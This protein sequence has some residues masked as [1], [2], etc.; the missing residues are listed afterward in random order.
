MSP[1]SKVAFFLTGHGFGHGVRNSAVINAL[2]PSVEVSLFTS[3]PES[4]FREEL[5]RPYRLVPCEIDCGCVQHDAIDVDVEATLER[6]RAL[7]ARRG[8]SVE[9]FAKAL[10][11]TGAELVIGDVPPLAFPIASAA[12]VPSWAVYNFTWTD[13][14]RPYVEERPRYRDMLLRM[15]ADYALAGRHIRLYPGLESPV[16]GPVE[17]AGLLCRPGRPRR[18]EFAA[19]FGLDPGKRWALVYVGSHGLD[20]ISWRDLDLHAGW[21]FMGLYPLEGAP[22]NYHVLAKD[23]SFGYAD[24]TASCDLVLGK[25]GYG[26]VAECLALGKPILFTGRTGFMEFPLLKEVVEGRGMGLELPLERLKALDFREELEVLAGGGHLP[27]EATGLAYILGK[28]GY[29]GLA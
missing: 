6:Y 26:L 24:L 3:L 23:A 29:P 17:Q 28:M 18:L 27:M 14:Y 15:E 1:V 13:I 22:A 10:V 7:D 25:L 12:G 9:R 2:P 8:E 19:K 21:E 16:P 11:E 5:R 20:G 4:F